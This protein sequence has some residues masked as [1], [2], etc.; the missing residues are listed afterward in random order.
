[1]GKKNCLQLKR[2]LGEKIYVVVGGEEIEIT[3]KRIGEFSIDLV[4]EADKDKVAIMR[5]ELL[6][7]QE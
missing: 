4:F 7:E 5:S 2:K 6:K 1:M 3:L